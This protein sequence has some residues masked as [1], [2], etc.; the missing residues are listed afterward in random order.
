MKVN[1]GG[2]DLFLHFQWVILFPKKSPHPP[3]LES[4]LVQ[5]MRTRNSVLFG[6]IVI[7]TFGCCE[8][9]IISLTSCI[10]RKLSVV[11][12]DQLY[13]RPQFI[14][15]LIYNLHIVFLKGVLGKIKRGYWKNTILN[16]EATGTEYYLF[17]YAF[18]GPWC[19][20]FLINSLW[21]DIGYN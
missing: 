1:H 9:S 16:Y 11:C 8:F 19:R 12:L 10:L 14:I 17:F 5:V 15:L 4:T 13:I 7:I 3:P 18:W 21:Q 20:R 6:R 2:S